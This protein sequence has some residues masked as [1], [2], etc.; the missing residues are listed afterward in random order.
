MNCETFLYDFTE[1]LYG[2][3]IRVELLHFLREEKKFNSME[4]LKKAMHDDMLSGEEYF[5]NNN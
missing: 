4:D 2:E 3:N 5:S 1:D